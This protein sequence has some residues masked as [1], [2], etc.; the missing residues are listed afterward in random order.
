MIAAAASAL[1]TEYLI[2]TSD[3]TGFYVELAPGFAP[4]DEG[5]L[6]VLGAAL[7][8]LATLWFGA[9]A[10]HRLERQTSAAG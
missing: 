9:I 4:G 5:M 1:I 6:Q 7:V 3:A 10:T 2:A 8:L